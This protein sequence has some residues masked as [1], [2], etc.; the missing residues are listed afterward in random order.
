MARHLEFHLVQLRV[1][2][3]LRKLSIFQKHHLR[4]TREAHRQIWRDC[5][6]RKL[7]SVNEI[8]SENHS[9]HLKMINFISFAIYREILQEENR[10][11]SYRRNFTH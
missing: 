4:S 7:V 9:A 8:L 6:K 5:S 10:V 3:L 1:M 2:V 11:N